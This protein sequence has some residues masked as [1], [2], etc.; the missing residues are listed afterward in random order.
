MSPSTTG[1]DAL[2][3]AENPADRIVPI[4]RLCTHRAHGRDPERT[5][6]TEPIITSRL[7]TAF[8]RI[9]PRLSDTDVIRA[10]KAVTQVPAA[11]LAEAN[12]TLHTSLTYSIVLTTDRGTQR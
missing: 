5:S 1:W 3:L 12:D 7:A 11:S 9:D 6:V 4:L 8:K 2:H 10:V